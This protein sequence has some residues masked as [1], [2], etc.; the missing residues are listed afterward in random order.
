M[1]ILYYSNFCKH[2][3]KILQ[4]VSKSNV[5]DKVSFI[6]IDA[7]KRNP[8]TGQVMVR[9]ENGNQV[10][11][12][13]SLAYVP[14]MLLVNEKYRLIYGDSIIEHLRPM[15]TGNAAEVGN[16]EPVCY[17][18]AT[19]S[20][21]V[22]S[23]MYTFCDMTP[24]DLSGKSESNRRP[25]HNYVRANQDII[26]INTPPDNY[27]PNKVGQDITIDK[28][29]QQRASEVSSKPMPPTPDFTY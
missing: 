13:P 12:P 19:S 24:D 17:D 22:R 18:F 27:S 14:A 21:S 6:C 26:T 1:D 28:L 5:S 7:R 25:M 3:K 2:S 9:L 11:M 15:L 8:A 23:E 10:V 4:A 16:Q 29:Q 20:G